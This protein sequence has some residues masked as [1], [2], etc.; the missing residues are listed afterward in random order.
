MTNIKRLFANELYL[1]KFRSFNEVKI[2][3]G[4]KM[5]VISGVNGVGKSNIISL[6]SSSSGVSK[7]SA[8][9]S[10][11]Q[12]EFSDFFHID[13]NENYQSY[14]LYLSYV[15]ESGQFALAKRL[16]F[17]DDTARNR[18]IR[19]IPRTTNEYSKEISITEAQKKA[20]D[21]YGSGGA[22]RVLIPTIYLSLSR[23]YPLGERNS[24]ARVNT[25][26]KRSPYAQQEVMEKYREWY[27]YLIPGSIQEDA[28]VTVIEKKVSSRDSLH[29]DIDNTP[30]LSQSIGQDNIGNIV[31]ALVDI[32]RLSKDE[33]YC[34]SILCIDEI[35]VSLHPDTQIRLFRLLESLTGE[36]KIQVMVSTHS[37]TILK[38]CLKKEEKDE[39]NYRV[40]YLKNPSLPY[41][42]KIKSYEL[43][44]ADMFGKFDYKRI[45]TRM[46]F[47]DNVGKEIFKSLIGAYRAI[48]DKV[49]NDKTGRVL[50]NPDDNYMTINQEIID[51]TKVLRYFDNLNMVVKHLGCDELI[52]ISESDP[53]FFKRIIFML[54]GDARIKGKN[55]PNVR[56]YLT[57]FYNPK[58]EG[59]SEREHSRNVI[60]APGFF[61]PE[62]YLYKIINYICKNELESLDF[63]REL[64]RNENT[65]LYTSDKIKALFYSLPNNFN[66]DSLKSIFG[67]GEVK[68]EVWNFVINTE[69]L[70]YYYSDYK[71]IVP[72]LDFLRCFSDAYEISYST[73]VANR[74]V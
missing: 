35:E 57:S 59:V 32:Y 1:K 51:L 9:G 43:L 58:T 2:P 34:G 36:F 20:K 60:F 65:A 53:A 22:A 73:T 70:S 45:C 40:I 56:D 69:M 72:L 52:N 27:N 68:G 16:S 41:V 30:T 55:K 25:I 24:P 44:K 50:R 23:L 66:N 74:Y 7:K 47:E 28:V 15:E 46:Y 67:N 42:T 6:I 19:I 4:R 63:W 64:D 62:S 54:D 13:A 5:T 12:P 71:K 3:L 49:N 10:N 33:N 8:L 26:T 18:G 61:A 11:F 48:L 17:K 37:L 21:N 39:S 29:M 31:S 38:E 14:K